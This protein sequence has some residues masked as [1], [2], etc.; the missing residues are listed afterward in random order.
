MLREGACAQAGPLALGQSGHCLV[1]S[2]S[3]EAVVGRQ[4]R[5]LP[6]AAMGLCAPR[7][8]LRAAVLF[9]GCAISEQPV[10]NSFLASAR[11][12]CCSLQAINVQAPRHHG[13]RMA[14]RILPTGAAQLA[15]F[16]QSGN[17]NG[18][19]GLGDLGQAFPKLISGSAF[20]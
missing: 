17:Q 2:L 13:P 11:R 12:H 20:F 9:G 14:P 18:G 7:A 6:S 15:F 8:S 3:A 19:G 1:R 10:L 5:R 16:P 4:T